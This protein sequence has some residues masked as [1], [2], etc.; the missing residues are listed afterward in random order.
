MTEEIKGKLP[1]LYST[2]E[3]ATEDKIAVVKFFTPWTNWT[4]YATEGSFICPEH[5]SF[6]CDQ[7]AKPWPDFLFFGWVHGLNREWSY[8][9]LKELES[10]QGPAGLK[11][12]RD[13]YFKPTKIS[14]L[15]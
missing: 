13:M 10:I 12:E 1:A 9:N 11:I 7:C 14:E 4:W 3:V 5:G 6:D 8:F 15:S 2:E